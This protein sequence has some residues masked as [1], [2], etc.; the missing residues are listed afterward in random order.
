[1]VCTPCNTQWMSRFENRKVKPVALPMIDGYSIEITPSQQAVLA[2][3]AN[4]R[5]IIIETTDPATTVST[6]RQREQFRVSNE[7]ASNTQVWVGRNGGTGLEE[8]S[9]RHGR[10]HIQPQALDAR[11]PDVFVGIDVLAMGHLVMFL[12]TTNHEYFGLI[13]PSAVTALG[14]KLTEIWPEPNA[15]LRWPPDEALDHDDRETLRWAL[16]G[17]DISDYRFPSLYWIINRFTGQRQFEA[18][19]GGDAQGNPGHEPKSWVDQRS[20]VPRGWPCHP[21][22]CRLS[23]ATRML[24]P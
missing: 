20:H 7:P 9:S 10:W 16:T 1:M 18:F 14:T 5:S 13:T 2:G 6:Q 19:F 24:V 22:S 11:G 15:I 8:A 12:I 4:L 3:W 23:H 21:S 17:V